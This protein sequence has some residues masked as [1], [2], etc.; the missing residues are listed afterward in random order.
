MPVSA[1]MQR[2]SAS[3]RLGR[4]M[5]P[6]ARLPSKTS[7]PGWA[8]PCRT[9]RQTAPDAI[10]R[11]P[12]PKAL[13]SVAAGC[14]SQGLRIAT[15]PCRSTPRTHLWPGRHWQRNAHPGDA[16][17][18]RQLLDADCVALIERRHHVGAHVDRGYGP[19][20]SPRVHVHVVLFEQHEVGA[21][22]PQGLDRRLGGPHRPTVEERVDEIGGAEAIAHG[23]HRR[24]SHKK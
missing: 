4:W 6:G 15:L 3:G 21:F 13:R 23:T 1:I 14:W 8:S 10:M 12:G 9:W 2:M 7:R 16:E 11:R 24:D 18:T 19:A 22:D 17:C 20:T 5:K